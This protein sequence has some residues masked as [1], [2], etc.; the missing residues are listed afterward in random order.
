MTIR[1]ENLGEIQDKIVRFYLSFGKQR[2]LDSPGGLDGSGWVVEFL[3]LL[4]EA[5]TPLT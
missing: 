1:D 2:P 5:A 4:A 3:G